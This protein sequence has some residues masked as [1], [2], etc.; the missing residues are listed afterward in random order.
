MTSVARG[1]AA[2]MR[3]RW[4]S[5]ASERRR[6]L[7]IGSPSACFS[8]SLTSW[9]VIRSSRCQKMRDQ[10]R[11]AA[12]STM[13]ATATVESRRGCPSPAS[14]PAAPR[15]HEHGVR[16]VMLGCPQHAG[17][18][19]SVT[20]TSLKTDFRNSIWPCAPNSRFQPLAID[21]RDSCGCM[22]SEHHTGRVLQDRRQDAGGGQDHDDRHQQTRRIRTRSPGTG[23]WR[24][25]RC[26]ATSRRDCRSGAAATGS[27]WL[28]P[29]TRKKLA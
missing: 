29:P 16:D 26:P 6:A 14:A 5:R 15:L 23:G 11:S 10:T 27:R 20:A 8:S 1:T 18:R 21:R 25:R 9:R 2:I 7:T 4:R 12:T 22:R 17:S 3:L 24:R 28:T 13:A 19:A